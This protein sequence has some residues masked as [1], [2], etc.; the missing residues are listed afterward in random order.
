VSSDFH[1][2]FR[3]L[4][5]KINIYIFSAASSDQNE[6]YNVHLACV[7]G[8]IRGLSLYGQAY[9]WPYSNYSPYSN[10]TFYMKALEYKADFTL[11]EQIV[12]SLEDIQVFFP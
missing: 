8:G 10:E 11:I 3:Y 7:A 12:K 1:L 2:L 9:T 5:N 6:F 4:Q